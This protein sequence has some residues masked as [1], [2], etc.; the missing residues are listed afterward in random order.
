MKILKPFI[1]NLM[2]VVI[3]S[4]TFISA[5]AQQNQEI[6]KWEN[7]VMNLE[8]L[9]FSDS[10][11]TILFVGSSSIR[12]WESIAEDMFPYHAMARGYGGAKLSDFIYYAH[13]IIGQH[14]CGA[15]AIFVANDITGQSG[16]PTSGQVLKLFRKTVKE[17]RKSHP[18][19]PVFWIEITPT[20]SRWKSWEQINQANQLIKKHCNKN[21]NLHYI[22]TSQFFMNEQGLPDEKYFISDMLHL[23]T[24]GY[25]LWSSCIKVTFDKTVPQLRSPK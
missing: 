23:N 9:P 12:L 22:P 16:D 3:F 15:I 20:P 10:E 18:E 19:I 17:I 7:E 1:L 24:E 8:K 21:K 25:R 11:N 4:T 5:S 2:F 13:R 6:T 14:R